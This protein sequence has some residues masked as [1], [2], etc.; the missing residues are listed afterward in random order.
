M[1]KKTP[2]P[3]Q[4]QANKRFLNQITG[5]DLNKGNSRD[6]DGVHKLLTKIKRLL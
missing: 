5:L 1:K 4:R 3:L 6:K 2:S